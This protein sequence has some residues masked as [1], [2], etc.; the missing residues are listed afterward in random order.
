MA[1][2]SDGAFI[3]DD[4][5]RLADEESL[6]AAGKVIV[7]LERVA[8]ALAEAR[9]SGVGVYVANTIDPQALAPFLARLALIDI[10]FPAFTDGRGFSLARLLRR[11]GF[12]GE[13]RASGRLTPDQYLHAIG[14]GVDRIE[15]PDDLAARHGEA[16][17]AK[18]L[19]ARSLSYQRGHAGGASILERRR[20]GAA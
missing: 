3:A 17:W 16:N 6:P 9:L 13:L 14:C 8:A 2:V 12:S 18:A 15:I 5:R 1:L 20:K 10:A 4:W 7:S 11:A 19:R